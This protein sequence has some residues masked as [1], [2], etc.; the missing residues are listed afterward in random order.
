MVPVPDAIR[1][2]LRVTSSTITEER[3][4]GEKIPVDAALNQWLGRTVDANVLMTEPGYPTYNASVMDGY[5]IRLEEM[6]LTDGPSHAILDKIFAGDDVTTIHTNASTD[7][8]VAYYVTTG[9]AIPDS[10]DCVVPME[11]CTVLDDRKLFIQPDATLQEGKWIRKIG[12]DMKAGSLVVPRG[13]VLDPVAIGLI[14]QSGVKEIVLRKPLQVGVMSTGNEL[15]L[16]GENNRLGKIPDVNRPVLKALVSSFGTCSVVDLGIQRDDDVEALTQAIEVALGSCDVIITSGGVS[17]GES[18][19]IEQVLVEK[20]GGTIHFGR[21]H[22]KPGKPTT[23]VSIPRKN[24]PA[25]LVFAMPGNP[26]SAVVCT[27]LLVRPCLDLLWDGPDDS[28]DTH[29]E[30]LTEMQY[31]IVQNAWVHAE[32]IVGLAHDMKL[33]KERPEYHRVTLEEKENGKILASS[34]GVQRSSRLMSLLNA[35]GLLI[36]PQG[37]PGGKMQAKAGEEY[38]ML[39]LNADRSKRVQ[40]CNSEHL[41]RKA[42]KSFRIGVVRVVP[43]EVPGLESISSTVQKALSG[44]KSGPADIVSSRTFVGEPQN[45]FDFVVDSREITDV[46]VVV[47][48]QFSGSYSYHLDA[49]SL[50]RKR[51]Q[52]V[53]DSMSLQARRGAASECAESALFECL[54]GYVPNGSGSIMICIPENGAKGALQNVRGLLKHALQVGRGPTA[55]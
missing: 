37:V 18:D 41:N 28:G 50:L 5:A 21:L 30:S 15:L 2:A 32:S 38:T 54:V 25:C 16:P 20:L 1:I 17:M 55:L 4:G 19:V 3:E 13:H 29:G 26:V 53:A 48:Q 10:F 33:D 52:K 27:Q 47:F 39:W 22:M 8:P 9:A 24:R 23:F 34:T 36:L 6:S 51:L 44:T 42:N 35:Q 11:Q 45:L 46:F 12:C 31:R 7:L 14:H 43:E 49:T 40:V